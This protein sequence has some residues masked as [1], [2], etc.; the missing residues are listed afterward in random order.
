MTRKQIVEKLDELSETI[1][2]YKYNTTKYCSLN[3]AYKDGTKQTKQKICP[4][5]KKTF[6]ALR[7][8][9]TYCSRQC[10]SKAKKLKPKICP[11][12]NSSFQPNHSSQIYCSRNCAKTS[13]K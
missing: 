13:K 1:E 4:S 10:Y 12:C 3:C 6:L 7:D 11:S 9:Q 5:C 8:T 2:A